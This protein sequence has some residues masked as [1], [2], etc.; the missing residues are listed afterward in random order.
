MGPVIR[1]SHGLMIGI[2]DDEQSTQ[3]PLGLSVPVLDSNSLDKLYDVMTYWQVVS[4]NYYDQPTSL[5]HSQPWETNSPQAENQYPARPGYVFR[6]YLGNQW[7]RLTQ[8]WWGP[9]KKRGNNRSFKHHLVSLLPTHALSRVPVLW[10]PALSYGKGPREVSTIAW[11]RTGSI[12]RS[13]SAVLYCVRFVG[14]DLR[15]REI[16]ACRARALCGGFKAYRLCYRFTGYFTGF[17]RPG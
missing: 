17:A 6:G 2:V 14:I 16:F 11:V 15:G 10:F 12:W 4:P 1:A 8:S 9:S 7:D 3:S 5:L 13:K